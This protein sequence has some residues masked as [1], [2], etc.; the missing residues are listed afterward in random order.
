MVLTMASRTKS[1][2]NI[3]TV[4]PSILRR[5]PAYVQNGNP[6]DKHVLRFLNENGPDGIVCIL[7]YGSVICSYLRNPGE[8]N[9]SR[10][11]RQRGLVISAYKTTFKRVTSLYAHVKGEK[12]VFLYPYGKS[13]VALTQSPEAVITGRSN[14]DSDPESDS[15]LKSNGRGSQVASKDVMRRPLFFQNANSKQEFSFKHSSNLLFDQKGMCCLFFFTSHVCT[16][17]R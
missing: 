11:V 6:S 2:V 9:N 1:I 7:V 10:V 17:Y 12:E 5:V 13:C 14:F 16:H 8:I 4:D 15:E 3:N